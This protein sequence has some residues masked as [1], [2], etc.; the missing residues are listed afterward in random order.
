MNRWK[1]LFCYLLGRHPECQFLMDY[2]QKRLNKYSDQFVN[3]YLK[4]WT[5]ECYRSKQL[6]ELRYADI[7]AYIAGSD[8]C[9]RSKFAPNYID[10]YFFKFLKG[11]NK[12]RISYAASFGTE[13]FEYSLEMQKSCTELLKEFSAISVR[14][15]S[16]IKLLEDFFDVPQGKAVEVLDPT[17]L[18]SVETYREVLK[19]YP[20]AESNYMFTYILDESEDK[21][22]VVNSISKELNLK[23]ISQ[24]AQ[25]GNYLKPIEPVELWLSRIAN[26]SFVVTD[27]FH[28]TVFSILF[29]K[30]FIVYVNPERGAARFKSLLSKFNLESRYIE[31]SEDYNDSSLKRDID[32]RI[33]NQLIETQKQASY[34]YLGNTL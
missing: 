24:K 10:D 11:T 9:W 5:K 23:I 29:N 32:W 2:K 12:K 28:G 1:N 30:P 6:Y 14:E 4:P 17:F 33:V 34:N 3:K 27:S 31:N 22:K 18:P 21:Q 20:I 25:T 7:D 26:A 8:Q 13:E 19:H 16:G 15:S